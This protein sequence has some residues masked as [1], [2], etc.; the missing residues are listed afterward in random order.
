MPSALYQFSFEIKKD[1]SQKWVSQKDILEYIVSLYKKYDVLRYV[2][3]NA[4]V[5]SARFDQDNHNWELTV[6]NQGDIATPTC[7]RGF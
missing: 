1:W 2:V 3:C 4:E 5:L 7:S 6:L